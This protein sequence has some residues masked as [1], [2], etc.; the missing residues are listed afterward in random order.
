MVILLSTDVR[1]D[2]RSLLC[3]S[4]AFKYY[5]SWKLHRNKR[6]VGRNPGSD[7][8]SIITRQKINSINYSN[9]KGNYS[10]SHAFDFSNCPFVKRWNLHC[11]VFVRN[12]WKN[13]VHW[14]EKRTNRGDNRPRGF[15]NFLSFETLFSSIACIWEMK[16]IDKRNWNIKHKYYISVI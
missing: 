5:Y 11:P 15:N 12:T 2:T 14:R 4:I 6:A 7:V 16:R 13:T 8:I 9:R 10:A 3:C 1:V